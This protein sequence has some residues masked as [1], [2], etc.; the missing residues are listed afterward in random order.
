MTDRRTPELS[1][2]ITAECA[3]LPDIDPDKYVLW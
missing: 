2:N 1:E 3:V